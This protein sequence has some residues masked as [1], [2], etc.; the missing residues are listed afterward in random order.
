MVKRVCSGAGNQELG[1][2][3]S[4]HFDTLTP[5]GRWLRGIRAG[6]SAYT[7]LV[8]VRIRQGLQERVRKCLTNG[9]R[10]ADRGA[11][12]MGNVNEFGKAKGKVGKVKGSLL[13]GFA[14][15][16][17]SLQY[18]YSARQMEM[19][20]KSILSLFLSLSVVA[21]PSNGPAQHFT[22]SALVGQRD[23]S[24]EP[25]RPSVSLLAP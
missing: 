17:R 24:S 6:H 1:R 7:L 25:A 5:S 23:E 4:A 11:A 22:R 14:F 9:L 16:C 12:V 3:D 10:R 8:P 19:R 2:A 13:H 21:Q 15:E 18:H 20:A